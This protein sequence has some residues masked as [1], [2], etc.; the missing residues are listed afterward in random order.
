MDSIESRIG[1]EDKEKN[2]VLAKAAIC[3]HDD[4]K[5]YKW[6]W[7]GRY[8]LPFGLL[9]ANALNNQIY[10]S[11]LEGIFVDYRSSFQNPHLEVKDIGMGHT[12][13]AHQSHWVGYV[14][15]LYY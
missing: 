4:Y 6:T 5:A 13:V 8:A 1:H 10:E 11:N 2:G 12:A 14:G 9:T 15:M 7:C 3:P